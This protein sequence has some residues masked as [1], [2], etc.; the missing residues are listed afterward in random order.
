ML[1]LLLFAVTTVD[2]VR[3]GFNNL[4][5]LA[6]I[7]PQGGVIEMAAIRLA[8]RVIEVLHI[9]KDCN[10]FHRGHLKA[11]RQMGARL[12]TRGAVCQPA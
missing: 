4:T 1:K 6:D 2:G 9:C 7:G 8:N 12:K 5:A 11:S 3:I 10:F